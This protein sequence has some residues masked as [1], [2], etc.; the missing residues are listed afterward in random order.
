MRLHER[1]EIA[2]TTGGWGPAACATSGRLPGLLASWDADGCCRM[3]SAGHLEWFGLRH[4]QM[5]GRHISEVLGARLYA[6]NRPYFADALAGREQVLESSVRDGAGRERHCEITYVPDR[7]PD[8]RVQGVFVQTVDVSSR[9]RAQSDLADAQALAGVGSWAWER[10]VGF[11]LSEE[12]VRIL[13]GDPNTWSGSTDAGVA[14]IHPDDRAWLAQLH[15]GAVARGEGWE[16]DHRV[17][18][19]DGEVRHVHSRARIALAPDGRLLRTWGSVLDLTE[20]IRLREE[21]EAR[22]QRLSDTMAML[23]HDVRQPLTA[24]LGYLDELS[25]VLRAEGTD[26]AGALATV[27]AC[28]DKAGRAGSRMRRLV[29]DILAVASVDEGTLVARPE[30]VAVAELVGDALDDVRVEAAVTGA[31]GVRVRAD[32]FHVRQ[33]LTNL[34]VNATKYGAPPYAVSVRTVGEL[35]EICIEDH[36]DGVPAEFVPDLFG[37]FSRGEHLARGGGSSAGLGLHLVRSLV[38]ANGGTVR[39]EGAPG[40]GARFVLSLPAA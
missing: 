39:Y 11:T 35:V 37:R 4:D 29:D 1:D 38:E 17:V 18:R 14:A 8:G 13:G 27:R 40:S 30:R 19:P 10:G 7:A 33:A 31:E 16:A 24:V 9:V 5:V 15:L 21:V 36:G 22:N 26:P 25:H 20:R 2:P 28:I 32:L 3:A 34:L 6:L 23:G 12:T